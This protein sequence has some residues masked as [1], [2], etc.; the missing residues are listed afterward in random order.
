MNLEVIRGGRARRGGRRA[1]E[2]S[3]PGPPPLPLRGPQARH[4][5]R[6]WSRFDQV[7]MPSM[8]WRPRHS[9][10]DPGDS[11]RGFPA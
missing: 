10:G 8:V 9:R 7:F 4:L 1:P 5:L 2:S 11:R 3:I 6:F